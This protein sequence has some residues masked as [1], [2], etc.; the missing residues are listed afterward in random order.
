MTLTH[1]FCITPDE[2]HPIVFIPSS[3]RIVVIPFLIANGPL[4]SLASSLLIITATCSIVIAA[5]S[6]FPDYPL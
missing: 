6:Q 3:M 4:L 5:E 2:Q 1:G